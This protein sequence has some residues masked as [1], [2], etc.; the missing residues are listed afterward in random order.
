MSTGMCAGIGRGALAGAA[1]TTA[2]NTVT[3]LDMVWRGRPSSSAPERSAE[4]LSE[5]SGLPVPGDERTRENRLTGLGALLGIAA[6]VGIGMAAGALRSAGV[7]M[8]SWLEPIAIGALAMAAM[9]TSMAA[10]GVTDPRNWSGKDWA[11]DV[12]PH[13]AY[14]V[15]TYRTLEATGV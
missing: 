8:P 12:I 10:V 2:L 9:D 3:Y 6:G 13:L 4:R 1:G 14:G 11:S 15:V 7:R 5:I